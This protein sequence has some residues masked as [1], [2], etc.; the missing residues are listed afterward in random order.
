[1]WAELQVEH[2]WIQLTYAST[3]NIKLELTYF[4]AHPGCFMLG[5]SMCRLPLGLN[6]LILSTWIVP[7]ALFP[8]LS[9]PLLIISDLPCFVICVCGCLST[10]ILDLLLELLIMSVKSTT[11][12]YFQE[13]LIQWSEEYDSMTDVICVT[14]TNLSFGCF[15]RIVQWLR[16]TT[17]AAANLT[18]MISWLLLE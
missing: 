13:R 17:L 9:N 3:L 7:W 10:A 16:N 8:I 6:I 11:C 15:Y 14:Q 5:N 1:M 2:K 12:P 4:T 18:R